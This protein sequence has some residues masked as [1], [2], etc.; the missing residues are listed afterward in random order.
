[1]AVNIFDKYGIKEVANVYFEALDSDP[2]AGVYRRL[3]FRS[4]ASGHYR[5]RLLRRTAYAGY[6]AYVCVCTQHIVAGSAQLAVSDD[7]GRTQSMEPRTMDC[8]QLLYGLDAFLHGHD[9][10]SRCLPTLASSSD[11]GQSYR[12]DAAWQPAAPT[13]IDD[14]IALF[15]PMRTLHEHDGEFPGAAAL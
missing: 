8:V 14:G 11:G 3:Y 9:F 13:R 12:G 10:P 6:S 4:D 2:A 1:M 5:L 7:G 15:V